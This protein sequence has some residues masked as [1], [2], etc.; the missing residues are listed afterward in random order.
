[1]PEPVDPI[2]VSPNGRRRGRGFALPIPGTPGPDNAITD[3]AGVAVGFTTLI[4]DGDATVRTGVTAIL[5]RPVEQLLEPIWAGAFSM[6]GNGEMTGVHWIEEAGWFTGPITITNTFSVGLAH[7]ATV[8]WM[9]RRFRPTVRQ[10]PVGPAG[11]G[12][13]LRWLAERHRGPARDRGRRHGRDRWRA[14]RPCGR[15]QC[16]RRHWH[17]H[18]RVQRR[19]RHSIAPGDARRRPLHGGRPGP[20]EPRPTLLAERVWR[21]GWR[22]ADRG[23]GSGTRSAARSSSSSPPMRH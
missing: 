10:V 7:H 13:D 1:M 17:D 4:A 9:I 5:P 12:R 14:A 15:R 8:R 16:R 19:H 20:G 18:L 6:N 11:S 23:A 2:L 22:Q 21:A 3:V